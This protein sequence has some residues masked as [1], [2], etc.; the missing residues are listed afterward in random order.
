M[1]SKILHPYLRLLN[2]LFLFFG[3]AACNNPFV[4]VKENGPKISG[5]ISPLV[6]Q[7][8][9]HQ[10]SFISQ[11]YALNCADD[12]YARLYPLKTDGTISETSIASVLVAPA[13]TY[14]FSA[15]SAGIKLDPNVKYIV[16]VNACDTLY[17][18]PVTNFNDQ[19]NVD[20]VT[21][22]VS[23]VTQALVSKKLHEVGRVELE[24]LILKLKQ[25]N[26]GTLTDVYQNIKNNPTFSN[27]FSEVF[28]SPST[29]LEN[30]IPRL[31]SENV[32]LF[33]QE[34]L[35]HQMSALAVHWD[36]NYQMVY[37]WKLDGVEVAT[38]N[39]WSYTPGANDQGD[40]TITL[41]IG[42]ND[43]SGEVDT[44]VPYVTKTYAVNVLNSAPAV[45]PAVTPSATLLD[46]RN[47]TLDLDTGIA[48]INCESF[49]SLAITENDATP[50]S[51]PALYNITCDDP[52]N[53]TIPYTLASAGDGAKILRLW[54]RD[55]SG[56]ISSPEVINL[57]LDTGAPTISLDNLANAY[58]GSTSETLTFSVTDSSGLQSI[59]L[60]YAQDG[61]TY[62]L[63]TSSIA[64]GDTSYTWT[65]PS[66]NTIVA[67]VKLVAVDTAGNSN[68]VE[69]SAFQIDSTAPAAPPIT[70]VSGTPTNSTSAAFT[71]ANC[72]DTQQ[73][74][75]QETATAPSLNDPNWINC[76][77]V[78]GAVAFTLSSTNGTKAL[79]IWAKDAVGNIST[80]SSIN[81]V[82]DTVAPTL[83]LSTPAAGGF[84]RGGVAQSV[85]W[86][87]ADVTSG[88]KTNSA[89][90]EISRD[91]GG[92]WSALASAQATSGPYSWTP[93]T[94]LDSNQH[95]LRLTVSDNALNT[96]TVTMSA[97]FT[98][99]S[100]APV[101]TS[102]AMNLNGGSPSTFNTNIQVNLAA[103]DSF[104]KIMQFC[105]KYNSATAPAA[106]DICWRSV[107][108]PVPN[109]T[110]AVTLAL[111]NF[112]FALGFGNGSYT[113]Y[114]WV[115]DQAG[116]MSAM[117]SAG[118]GT[119]GM[120]KATISYTRPIPVTIDSV[121]VLASVSPNLPLA[122]SEQNYTTGQSI[123]VKWKTT[124]PG[125]NSSQGFKIEYT[126]NESTW[127]TVANLATESGN[128]CTADGAGDAD[129]GFTGCYPWPSAPAG[130]F[131]VR[132]SVN[133]QYGS[134]NMT[135]AQPSNVSPFSIMAGNLDMSLGGDARGNILN[136]NH[137]TQITDPRSLAIGP[138]G[139][140]YFKDAARGILKFDPATGTLKLWIPRGASGDPVFSNTTRTSATL[141]SPQFI[142]IDA[143]GNL[144]I[145]DKI[146][147]HK[148][149]A[150][151][152]KITTIVGGGVGADR[153]DDT[154]I[155]GRNYE[156]SPLITISDTLD[157]T[158]L[159]DVLSN[160]DILFRS[161][162]YPSYSNAATTLES[163][164]NNFR[165][166]KASEDKIYNIY[167]DA[168]VGGRISSTFD[169]SKCLVLGLSYTYDPTTLAFNKYFYSAAGLFNVGTCSLAGFQAESP[170]L[171]TGPV[172]LTGGAH[173]TVASTVTT[174]HPPITAATHRYTHR[175]GKDGK[176]Y[177]FSQD[178]GVKVYNS[179]TNTYSMVYGS[180]SNGS[181]AD[182]TL[183]LSCNS[184]VTDLFVTREGKIYVIDKGRVRIIDDSGRVQTIFGQSIDYGQGLNAQSARFGVLDI[185]RQNPTS[186]EVFVLDR[187][188]VNIRKFG[189]STNTTLVA[190]NGTNSPVSN[191]GVAATTTVLTA[192]YPTGD[193]FDLIPG[194]NDIIMSQTFNSRL[195]K[196]NSGTGRW[197]AYTGSTTGVYNVKTGDGQVGSNL[198]FN[199]G[200][201]GILGF[202]NNKIIGTSY[203]SN[204]PAVDSTF[205]T[206]DPADSFRQSALLGQLG[207]PS[208]VTMCAD[209]TP[210]ET[211][212]M[213]QSY[214]PTVVYNS[215]TSEY[216][217]PDSQNNRISRVGTHK[218]TWANL[219]QNY[220]SYAIDLPNNRV[221]FCGSDG[222]IWRLYQ[223]DVTTS[224]KTMF[225]T[226][227]AGYQCGAGSLLIDDT[228]IPRKL[229]FPLYKNGVTAIMGIGSLAVP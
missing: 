218:N 175:T 50:P 106:N 138:T 49:N 44:S 207:F 35:T 62:S 108:D 228:A 51:N 43:G 124:V 141:R 185:L 90:L 37:K 85:S 142:D 54:A 81:I 112:P 27:G 227:P 151:T 77:T 158:H 120:D 217:L 97:N 63:V 53:Q 163:G 94:N 87:T 84:F 25:A 169:N 71:M 196:L 168:G 31:A 79:S 192:E 52:I 127:T 74:I 46:Q 36:G 188:N 69:S 98:I 29:V 95:R 96:T 115:K 172:D 119:D 55:A 42:K 34:K 148:Y 28:L 203:Y 6:G 125:T 226:W 156:I 197:E 45:V 82:L 72:T 41:L 154:V 15:K 33:P 64:A 126:S 161:E 133:D 193:T 149:I 4:T 173:L 199:A 7:I 167:V 116:N 118:A 103:T 222:T 24:A 176:V 160:G 191:F 128:G 180:G 66:H 99:D 32:T 229:I 208:T 60:Y 164:T 80:A 14:S 30:I 152:D 136:Y 67:K 150:A 56:N 65:I 202:A 225:T 129:N 186:G 110:P 143:L 201:F 83:S 39:Q 104:T 212:P 178:W 131:R 182:N 92:T 123:F 48:F 122:T 75:I 132:V 1:D 17:Y 135:A 162:G 114:A 86:T 59:S 113:V 137:G 11:A 159:F 216:L 10:N 121:L 19:Q 21:T 134:T 117:S 223:Y 2:A 198:Q 139:E 101:L 70:L 209:G 78:A 5:Q 171:L 155:G 144:Y 47:L 195:F 145:F 58:K 38:T 210:Q 91:G 73:I 215:A 130:L 153:K 22:L 170:V 18:R 109:L 93:P 189:P 179:A 100:V 23:Y 20:N 61:S 224:T 88:L 140:M 12:V 204:P 211:C 165:Y 68:F 205:K 221:Y 107:T 219:G 8:V 40:H 166:Y 187:K 184:F 13:A 89:S 190:G 26:A 76:T 57:T 16:E 146:Y 206:Y 194:T 111:S 214:K 220:R 157:E 177:A 183:A 9:S 147:I 102:S 105:L 200:M 181:C 174:D 213:P 3:L